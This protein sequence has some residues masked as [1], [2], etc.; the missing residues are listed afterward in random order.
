MQHPRLPGAWPAT[1]SRGAQNHQLC[2]PMPQPPVPPPPQLKRTAPTV[3]RARSTA[4]HGPDNG[5]TAPGR[6][7]RHRGGPPHAN[8]Q[9]RGRARSGSAAH[10]RGHLAR[11]RTAASARASGYTAAG[12]GVGHYRTHP[13]GGAT[14]HVHH[15]VLPRMLA[16]TG[17]Y[18]AC[19]NSV[20]L[21]AA[22][23]TPLRPAGGSRAR[24]GATL[25]LLACISALWPAGGSTARRG[26]TLL[27]HP[28]A[29]PV[30]ISRA[31]SLFSH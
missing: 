23:S 9:R 21:R 10:T 26:C 16:R 2:V 29:V 17:R 6:Y 3:Q 12:T 30:L 11:P 31:H 25:P 22:C 8:T 7:L 4:A 1:T 27:G 15:G 20:V 28:A 18:C 14:A 13:V 19:P 24:T 5:A